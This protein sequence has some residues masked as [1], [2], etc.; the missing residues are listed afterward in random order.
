[1]FE[2]LG[3]KTWRGASGRAYL[4]TVYSLVG[5][6]EF[7]HGSYLLVASSSD[8]ASKKVLTSGR[9]RP[10]APSLNLAEVRRLGASIAATEVHMLVTADEHQAVAAEFDLASA[11]VK[12]PGKLAELALS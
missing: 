11:F 10:Q 9:S 7:R 1:M 3:L 2:P 4:H 8:G 5:C 6:P 12:S